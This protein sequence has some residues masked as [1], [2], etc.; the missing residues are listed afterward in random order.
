MI[1]K[2]EFLIIG[3][4]VA[5]MSYIGFCGGEA[6]IYVYNSG[7]KDY[8]VNFAAL[9]KRD[10]TFLVSRKKVENF[11]LEDLK[12]KYVIGGRKG[13]MPEMT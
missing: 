4:G 1:K 12:G 9:T 11:K 3:S 10:G 8:I 5:G 6:S 13:G 7:N 2:C